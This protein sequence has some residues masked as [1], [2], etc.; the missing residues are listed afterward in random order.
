VT[1]SYPA[2]LELLANTG[3]RWEVV[4]GG[5]LGMMSNEM[6]INL[7][8]RVLRPIPTSWSSH[9]N[10]AVAQMYNDFKQDY[11]L[12]QGRVQL[13]TEH[14]TSGSSA[15]PTSSCSR[16]LSGASASA[17]TSGR[18]PAAPGSTGRTPTPA[19]VAN[20]R[21]PS[22]PAPV[23]RAY[24]NMLNLLRSRGSRRS[25]A[26][27]SARRV[28]RVPDRRARPDPALMAEVGRLTERNNDCIR[29]IA[30]RFNIPALEATAIDGRPELFD[31][32]CHL[33]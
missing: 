29:E 16:A 18:T 33:A 30:N 15:T 1:D 4:N 7:E 6:L 13:R 31:D 28:R 21:D 3:N 25:C 23:Q 17:G 9:R 11:A 2:N 14:R 27:P 8:L 12:P 26:M 5:V 10:E 32:D 20:A 22:H 24:E 19:G